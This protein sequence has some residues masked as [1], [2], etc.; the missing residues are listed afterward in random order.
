ML[1]VRL[2]RLGARSFAFR[3][4][5][6]RASDGRLVAEAT[7]VQV[8]YDYEAG[9]SMDMPTAFRERLLAIDGDPAAPA[10]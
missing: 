5:L 7:S 10:T 1:G 4:R 2:D 8:M 9:R 3:Y 6:E